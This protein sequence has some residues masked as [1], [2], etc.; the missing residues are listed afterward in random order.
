[1]LPDSSFKPTKTYREALGLSR[2]QIVKASAWG[3]CDRANLIDTTCSLFHVRDSPSQPSI[4]LRD[5]HQYTYTAHFE[6][7][8]TPVAP[9]SLGDEVDE[10][11]YISD[12]DSDVEVKMHSSRGTPIVRCD[13]S[14]I[15]EEKELAQGFRLSRT[16]VPTL[17]KI[18]ST[19]STKLFMDFVNN[20]YQRKHLVKST[21]FDRAPMSRFMRRNLTLLRTTATD[22]EMQPLDASYNGVI[23]RSVLVSQCV[24]RPPEPLPHDLQSNL[25]ERTSMLCHVPE[26]NLVVVGSLTGRVALLTLTKAGAKHK[27]FDDGGGSPRVK[28]GFRVDWILPRLQEEKARVRPWAPLHGIA[29]SPIPHAAAKGLDLRPA[30]GGHKYMRTARYRLLLHYADHTIL[31]YDIARNAE[32]GP[33][34]FI[35]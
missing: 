8:P 33:D 17:G 13:T 27:V 32:D 26:L 3:A 31:K 24:R 19:N 6:R 18:P 10:P 20:N 30:K 14:K 25:A 23:C 16:I 1:V 22:I 15:D 34:L 29:I 9:Y 12:S 21:T 35:F 4:Y 2:K 11:E 28:R 7:N 5:R